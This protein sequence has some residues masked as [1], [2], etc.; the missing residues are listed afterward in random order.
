MKLAKATFFSSLPPHRFVRGEK[1]RFTY[2]VVLEKMFGRKK[3]AHKAVVSCAK[4]ALKYS[5]SFKL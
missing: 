4:Q 1:N 5:F 2:E 3:T